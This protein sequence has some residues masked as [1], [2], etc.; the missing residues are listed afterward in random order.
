MHRTCADAQATLR[1]HAG[2]RR[3]ATGVAELALKQKHYAEAI[4]E[5]KSALYVDVLDA[6]VHRVLGEAY[7]G[8][9]E[10]QKAL[11][12][13][14]AATQLKPKDDE[15]ELALAKAL[16]TAGKKD[17]AKIHFQA[18]LDRDGKNAEA[19]SQLEALK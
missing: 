7:L 5:A 12:E 10:P 3:P 16:A 4:R 2:R 9:H 8:V 6:Q 15:V 1:K 11:A 14:E 17:E 18:I 19:R 13:L